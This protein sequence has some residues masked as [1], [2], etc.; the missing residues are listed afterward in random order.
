[1]TE[2]NNT[3]NELKNRK[4]QQRKKYFYTH[5]CVYDSNINSETDDYDSWYKKNYSVG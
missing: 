4:F 5:T 3:C 2:E 1:M